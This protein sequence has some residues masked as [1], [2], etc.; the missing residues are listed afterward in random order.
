M[1]RRWPDG[2]GTRVKLR[3]G[4]VEAR[5]TVRGSRVLQPTFLPPIT[6]AGEAQ[7][8]ALDRHASVIE[9][10]ATR[11]DRQGHTRPLY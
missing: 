3:K 7:V 8:K 10:I 9:R 5:G 11:Q 1:L 2:H 4:D 6:A